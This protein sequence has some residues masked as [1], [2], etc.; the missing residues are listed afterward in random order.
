[1][2][3]AARSSGRSPARTPPYRPTGVRT[4]LNT[5]ALLT[6]ARL[7]DEAELNAL[8][9]R[10]ERLAAPQKLGNG[11]PPLLA[12]VAREVVHVH[13][14]EAVGEGG[15]EAAA[16]PKRVLHRLRPV[17][18]PGFDRLLQYLREIVERLRPE[19]APRHVDSERQRQARL[20]QPPL[21]EVDD[22]AQPFRLVR[23]LAFVNQQPRVGAPGLHLVEDLVERDL[24][25]TEVAEEEPQD[26]ERGG[27]APRNRDLDRL[28]LLTLEWLTRHDDRP[29]SR[30]HARSVGEHCIVALNERIGMQRDRGR[31]EPSLERPV[32]QGLNVPQHV[33][34]L[35][36]ARV[37]PVRGKRPEHECVVGIRAVA[38]SDQHAA[39]LTQP[40]YHERQWRGP[41]S[42]TRSRTTS[43]RST[44]SRKTGGASR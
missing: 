25:E 43:R 6:R 15:V 17:R 3:S 40:A 38:E 37:D 33:L 13:A 30:A 27:H 1:M 29:V 44:S 39:R 23:E 41:R 2:T 12:V 32:V 8:R 42:R 31:L 36:P 28:Q 35:E 18:E 19:I 11:L 16:E 10:S 26:E 5:T 34:E 21:A 20:E 7:A 24:A 4:P 9:K 22:L 14:D